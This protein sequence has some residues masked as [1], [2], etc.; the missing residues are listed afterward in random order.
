MRHAASFVARWTENAWRL[1]LVLHA[2]EHGTNAHNVMLPPETAQSA[3]RIIDWFARGQLDLIQRSRR[4][5][6]NDSVERLL[7]IVRSKGGKVKQSEL[8]N[9]HGLEETEV[10]S[11][12]AASRGKLRIAEIL[13]SPKGGRR[14]FNVELVG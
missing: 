7:E 10:R 4:D 14:S 6:D 1:A 12:V 9:N 8:K 13:P 3:T 5:E 2:A 11:I